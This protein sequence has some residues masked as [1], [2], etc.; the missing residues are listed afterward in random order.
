MLREDNEVEVHLE[1]ILDPM[2]TFHTLRING[3]RVVT[4]KKSKSFSCMYV[5]LQHWRGNGLAW[6]PVL[7][8]PPAAMH[9]TTQVNHMKTQVL[10]C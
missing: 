1:V 3:T 8:P 4:T 7:L 9:C 2:A 10:S 5:T 6:L